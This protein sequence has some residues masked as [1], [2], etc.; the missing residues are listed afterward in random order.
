MLYSPQ[1]KIRGAAPT[2][3]Y[4]LPDSYPITWFAAAE[5]DMP[6]LKIFQ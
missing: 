3:S 5:D 2:I 6:K 4:I 1:H